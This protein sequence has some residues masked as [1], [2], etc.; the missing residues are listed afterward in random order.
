M[1]QE[2]SSKRFKKSKLVVFFAAFVATAYL[3]IVS[4]DLIRLHTIDFI[5]SDIPDLLPVLAFLS[6]VLIIFTKRR[7]LYVFGL[8]LLSLYIALIVLPLIVPMR[9]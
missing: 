8:I 5:Y 1:G 4:A 7:S 2:I 9:I 3:F 6:S